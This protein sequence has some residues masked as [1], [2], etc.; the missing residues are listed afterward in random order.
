MGEMR[1]GIFHVGRLEFCEW[2]NADCRLC[3]KAPQFKMR[4]EIFEGNEIGVLRMGER[5]LQTLFEGAAIQ[6]EI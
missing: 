4:F 5:R 1:P 6:D 3:L 2:A